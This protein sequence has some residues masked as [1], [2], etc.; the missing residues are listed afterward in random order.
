MGTINPKTKGTTPVI[1]VPGGNIGIFPSLTP[2]IEDLY[3][4][5]KIYNFPLPVGNLMVNTGNIRTKAKE[6]ASKFDHD[7]ETATPY[8][9]QA[10]LEDPNINS[11][12]T[13]TDNTIIFRFTLPGNEKSNL[14]LNLSGNAT[15]EVKDNNIIQGYTASRNRGN[16]TENRKYFYALL[17]K[18]ASSF[19]T[20]QNETVTPGEKTKTGTGIGLYANYLGTTH[21][22]TVELRIGFSSNSADE[23]HVFISSEIG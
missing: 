22:Q 12:F 4:A 21:S 15:F 14:L 18:P 11:E 19:G 1:K 9:Y 5:D 3:L 6:N 2:E 20:W 10:L 16:N 23:A 7:D 8:Y 17:S 13:L